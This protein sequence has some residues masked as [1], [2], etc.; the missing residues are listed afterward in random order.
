[1]LYEWLFNVKEKQRSGDEQQWLLFADIAAGAVRS[2]IICC[3]FQL[4]CLQCVCIN[5]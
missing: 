5:V 4:Y 3:S 1:M 2:C